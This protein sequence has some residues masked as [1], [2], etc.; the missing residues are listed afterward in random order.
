MNSPDR[1]AEIQAVLNSGANVTL[2]IR[3]ESPIDSLLKE[4][5]DLLFISEYDDVCIKKNSP[6][7]GAISK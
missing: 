5:K 6:S 2:M 4:R 3:K 7:K 1:S